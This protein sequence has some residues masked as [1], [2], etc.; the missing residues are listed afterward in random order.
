MSR[1]TAI[2]TTVAT[3]FTFGCLFPYFAS[4]QWSQAV[5]SESIITGG[6]LFDGIGTERVPNPGI[7]IRNGKFAVIGQAPEKIHSENSEV[8]ELDSGVTNLTSSTLSNW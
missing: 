8:I 6:W 2:L 5:E 4:A 3:A 1:H 7:V